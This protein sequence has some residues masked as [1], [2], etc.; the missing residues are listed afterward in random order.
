M[1]TWT[2]TSEPKQV[3]ETL[4][5]TTTYGLPLWK[6]EPSSSAN[7]V[8]VGDVGYIH[9]GEFY[10]LFNIANKNEAFKNAISDEP[11]SQEDGLP[12]VI[13]SKGLVYEEKKPKEQSRYDHSDV[14]SACTLIAIS[15]SPTTY[16]FTTSKPKGAILIITSKLMRTGITSNHKSAWKQHMDSQ[17]SSWPEPAVCGRRDLLLVHTRFMASEWV[18]VVFDTKSSQPSKVFVNI[19]A[20]ADDKDQRV[21]VTVNHNASKLLS[22]VRRGRDI[23]FTLSQKD[24]PSSSTLPSHCVFLHAFRPKGSGGV[25]RWNTEDTS[26]PPVS[27]V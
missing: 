19:S 3:Y 18:M 25:V 21:T 2:S 6:P 8:M 14:W 9:N 7:P 12:S 13:T 26:A 16:T 10:R 15:T 20:A 11:T 24:N 1:A 23:P 5:K 17:L 4:L 22:F 27:L